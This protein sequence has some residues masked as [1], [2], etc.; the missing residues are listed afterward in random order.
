MEFERIN[1]L[2]GYNEHSVLLDSK[3]RK[4]K[5]Y[6]SFNIQ[7]KENHMITSKYGLMK[8]IRDKKLQIK[9]LHIMAIY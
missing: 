1:H 4:A 3:S 9:K 6:Q 7:P 8:T 5:N 2:E